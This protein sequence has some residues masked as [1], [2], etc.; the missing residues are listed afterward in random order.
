MSFV[1]V[2]IGASDTRYTDEH[3]EVRTVDNSMIFLPTEGS[4]ITPDS[5]DLDSSLELRIIKND[6]DTLGNFPAYVMLGIMADRYRG[7]RTAPD[8]NRV[9]HEQRVNYVSIVMVCGLSM[10]YAKE[11]GRHMENDIVLNVAVPPTDVR[12]AA[13]AFSK[14]LVGSYTVEFP[15]YKGG[16]K[17]SFN[18]KKVNT[19]AESHMA[20]TSFFFDMKGKAKNE[21]KMLLKGTVLSL[22]IG[23]STTDLTVIKNGR[24]LDRSGRTIRLG[25]NIA[26]DKLIEEISIKFGIEYPIEEAEK[27][28]REGRIQMGNSYEDAKELVNNAKRELAAQLMQYITNYFKSIGIPMN[29]INAVVVSGG[30]SLPGKYKTENN[31]EFKTS[32]PMSKF[33]TEELVG[34]SKN[35]QVIEYG[36]DARLANIIGLYIRSMLHHVNTEK[37]LGSATQSAENVNVTQNPSVTN[38][39]YPSVG[40]ESSL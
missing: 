32:E 29:L 28:M 15:K 27:V 2:D 24:Y 12:A 18:I 34:I 36:D 25:G 26:R 38:G 1:C 13:D 5:Q 20:V 11:N 40:I 6:G 16:V 7:Y 9:K 4:N 17:V 3:G 22:D 30:G 35:T 14:G 23:A 21:N 39:D 31:A 37:N 8:I 19:Y 33:I 10:I